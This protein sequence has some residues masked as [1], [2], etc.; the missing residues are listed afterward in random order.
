MTISLMRVQDVPSAFLLDSHNQQSRF[1]FSSFAFP[2]PQRSPRESVVFAMA[3]FPSV[4]DLRK[5]PARNQYRWPTA[6]VQIPSRLWPQYGAGMHPP[7]GRRWVSGIS[8]FSSDT[9]SVTEH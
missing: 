3:F 8:L 5:R 9:D 7:I 4:V 1:D 2:V 6:T